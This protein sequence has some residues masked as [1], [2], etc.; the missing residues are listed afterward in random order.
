MLYR[1]YKRANSLRSAV[2]LLNNEDY[3]KPYLIAGGTDLFIRLKKGIIKPDLLL[4]ISQIKELKKIRI[5]KGTVFIGAA[6]TYTELVESE[7]IKNELPLVY[8]ASLK[9]GSPQIRNI[10]T[11]GGNICTASGAADM[12]PCLFALNAKVILASESDERIVP[13]NDFVVSNRKT[14]IKLKEILK[15]ILID[16]PSKTCSTAFL[17]FGFRESLAIS[18]VNTAV[19]LEIKSGIIS[20]SMIVL[21]CV[22]PRAITC[23]L[24]QQELRG[25]A[26][27][28]KL[29]KWAGELAVQEISP[30]DDI[31][32]SDEFRKHL[33]RVLVC[34]ALNSASSKIEG[35]EE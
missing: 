4:D 14:S 13:I 31:R 30:V 5:A 28:E 7:L 20:D 29:F 8:D 17:K 35:K 12:V 26:P 24:A 6:V 2:S 10:G 34:R 16:K 1:T 25:K 32:G 3:E 18:V 33:A 21:G 22:G 27:S 23:K 15:G 11:I 9:V 19:A